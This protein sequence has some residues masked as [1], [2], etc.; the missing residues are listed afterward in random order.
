[1]SA[2]P[3]ASAILRSSLTVDLPLQL[4]VAGSA[5]KVPG[6]L[7]GY[8]VDRYLAVRNHS[9]RDDLQAL[10]LKAGETVIVR[11]FAA[12]TAFGFRSTVEAVSREPE[13]LVWLRYPREAETHSV[14]NAERHACQLPCMIGVDESP[15]VRGL[16][17]DLSASGCQAAFSS[18][19]QTTIEPETPLKLRLR[20][21]DGD[22]INLQGQIKRMV[23]DGEVVRVG[24]AFATPA[25]ELVDQLSDF[26]HVLPA[27]R[28][29]Q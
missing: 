23:D 12:G 2:D 16:L 29:A 7:V 20:L 4:Q 3:T 6:Y 10:R 11:Y 26:L 19:A 9:V 8:V 13:F 24:V 22:D 1:M 21:P 17:T 18:A 5:L 28:G 25:P 15:E 27:G 14:R